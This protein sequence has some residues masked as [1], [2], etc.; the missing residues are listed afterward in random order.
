MPPDSAV[1]RVGSP[2]RPAVRFVND[3]Q[4]DIVGHRGVVDANVP[5]GPVTLSVLMSR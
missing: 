4:L 1:V 5:P 2:T 3:R